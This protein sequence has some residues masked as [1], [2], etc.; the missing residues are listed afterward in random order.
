VKGSDERATM[1]EPD[2]PGRAPSREGQLPGHRMGGDGSRLILAMEG[3][4]I[5]IAIFIQLMSKHY[6]YRA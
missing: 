2:P 4:K 3:E 6:A 1:W 5:L